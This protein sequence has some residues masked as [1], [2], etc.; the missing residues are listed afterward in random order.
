MAVLTCPDCGKP[1][2]D[3]APACPHCGRPNVKTAGG[4]SPARNRIEKRGGIG[5]VG[6]IVILLLAGVIGQLF[7]PHEHTSGSPTPTPRASD[8]TAVTSPPP[9]PQS[10]Q[11][12]GATN[13][14]KTE[15]A[16][17]QSLTRTVTH[18]DMTT[19]D[20][21]AI[22]CFGANG[23]QVRLVKVGRLITQLGDATLPRPAHTVRVEKVSGESTGCVGWTLEP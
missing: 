7:V 11:L 5:C 2:S 13:L 1:V 14:F 15:D 21:L 8:T 4:G 10:W 3:A 18:G 19:Q 16:L 6:A 22:R 9:I 12:D 23:D 20:V 17:L